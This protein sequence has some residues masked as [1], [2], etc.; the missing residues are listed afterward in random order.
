VLK[1]LGAR[2][3]INNA[4]LLGY[5]TYDTGK[6]AFE[7]LLAACGRDWRRFVAAV[8]TVQEKDFPKA[9]LEDFTEVVEALATRG[10][11]SLQP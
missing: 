11:T 4:T 6:P 3:P 9:Q 7:R 8:S 10:C 5:R 1:A 2:R